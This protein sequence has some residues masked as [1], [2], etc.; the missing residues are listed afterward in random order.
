[1]PARVRLHRLGLI[2]TGWYPT[3]LALSSDDRTL[4]VVNTKG[5]GHDA[6]FTGDPKPPLFA[7]SNATWSTLQ[8]ID[9]ASVRLQS[10]TMNALANTRRVVAAPPAYPKAISHVVVILEENKTFDAM[11]GDLGAPLFALPPAEFGT[12]IVA[13][14]EKW[15]K[16]IKFAG[17]QPQ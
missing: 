17:L 7:D 13:E 15:A 11:L 2:P 16:V 8:K 1:M 10:S 14:T 4:F 12:L 3:A 9:L 5:F 6:G